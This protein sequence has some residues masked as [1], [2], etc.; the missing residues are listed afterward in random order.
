MKVTTLLLVGLMAAPASAQPA[1]TSARP[2][3]VLIIA[4][5]LGY[6]DLSSYGAPD[7]KTPNL[8]RLAREGVRLTDYY[9]NAPVCT[10]TR[11]ALMTGRYQQ[12]VKLER[13]LET[14]PA[15][16]STGL[17][18]GLPVTGRSLPQLIKNAGYATGPDWQMAS[19]LQAEFRPN[20]HGFDYFWGYLPATSTGTRT[21]EEMAR[22]DL[23]ENDKRRRRSRAISRRGHQTRSRLHRRPCQGTLLPRS[24]VGSPHWPFQSPHHPS[25]AVRSDNSMFQQPGDGVATPPTRADYVAI[26]EEA[27][28]NIGTI[29]GTLQ[30][31]GVA[32][33]TLVIY[34][35]DNGGEW[36]S[37]NAPFFHRK[38]TLWEGGVR[39]PAILRWPAQLP[40]GRVSSQVAITMDLTRTI[41]G[42][43][44]A[45][46]S[47]ARLEGIDLLPPLTGTFTTRRTYAVLAS[48]LSRHD[49]SDRSEADDWKVLL[50]GGQQLSSMCSRDPGERNDLAAQHPDIVTKLKAQIEAW[51]KDVDNEAG[52][53]RKG[54]PR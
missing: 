4:D 50:D 2:N 30:Q 41:L 10:P 16:L 22:P 18:V 47:D 17:K 51:E 13:P 36:L 39:V 5:D 20:L 24:G 37:R 11:A 1:S 48:S 44:N 15:N 12:R 53:L 45:N 42:V 38:D 25:V 21:C 34:I 49:S 26:V 46:S 14:D 6:G 31:H 35:S 9:A 23:W 28:E 29:L 32:E 27:D 54:S 40:S 52:S 33:N 43:A 7:I 3:V 19:W 8:D